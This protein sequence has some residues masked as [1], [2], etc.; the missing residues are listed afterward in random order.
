MPAMTRAVHAFTAG[1]REVLCCAGSPPRE[2]WGNGFENIMVCLLPTQSRRVGTKTPPD[3]PIGFEGLAACVGALAAS[4]PYECRTS[5][6]GAAVRRRRFSTASPS[7]ARE[8]TRRALAT[9]QHE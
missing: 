3:G 8:P 7:T 9:T 5:S 1:G 2:R 6:Q 4:W